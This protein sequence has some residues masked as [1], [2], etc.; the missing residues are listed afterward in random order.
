MKVGESKEAA[1]PPPQ[2]G[3]IA[4]SHVV[5]GTEPTY[6]PIDRVGDLHTFGGRTLIVTTVDWDWEDQTLNVVM[7]PYLDNSL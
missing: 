1:S 4:A 2:S 3:F 6:P 5:G 7:K